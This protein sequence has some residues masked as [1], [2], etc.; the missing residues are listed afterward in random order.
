MDEM[1]CASFHLS[2]PCI[3]V[4]I[5]S[6]RTEPT[7]ELF[8]VILLFSLFKGLLN[9]TGQSSIELKDTA[10]E[11]LVV[12]AYKMAKKPLHRK[13]RKKQFVAWAKS[14][15]VSDPSP[16]SFTELLNKFNISVAVGVGAMPKISAEFETGDEAAA[17]MPEEAQADE[18]AAASTTEAAPADEGV[19]A[20]TTEAAPADEAVAASA[21]AAPAPADDTALAPVIKIDV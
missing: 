5:I 20:S 9:M 14:I 21:D 11:K 17:V 16:C 2:Y 4:F 15:L 3:S 6:S 19:A 12:E 8:Q 7:P 1:V 13:I 10:M 18:A